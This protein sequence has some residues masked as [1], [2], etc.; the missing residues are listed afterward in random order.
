MIGRA[1]T[2]ISLAVVL[3]VASVGVPAAV[4]ADGLPGFC[5]DANGVTVVVD[6]NEIGGGIVV[7]CAVGAQ[8]NG[9]AALENAGFTVAG[10]QRWGKAFVCRIEGKPGTD[11]EPCLN[12]PP[13]SAYWSYWNAVDGGSWQYSNFGLLNRTPPSGTFEGWSFAKD[14]PSTQL[15]APGIAPRRPATARTTQPPKTPKPA[16]GG[17]PASSQPS[18]SINATTSA[19]LNEPVESAPMEPSPALSQEWN[20]DLA[21]PLGRTGNTPIGSIAALGLLIGLIGAAA[22]I[23]RRRRSTGNS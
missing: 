10:T 20:G 22:W 7:R 4:A 6:F 17:Q 13:A 5:P 12:T 8:A 1:I 15:P 18:P 2:A 16:A 11:I 21:E 23:H 3:T 9:L 14:R 19:S